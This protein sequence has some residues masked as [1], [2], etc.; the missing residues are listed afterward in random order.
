MIRLFNINDYV[1]DTGALTGLHD[2]I[3]DEFEQQIADFVGAKYACGVSSATNA[4]FLA[5]QNKDITVEVPSIIPPVV[6]NAILTSGNHV[7]FRDDVDWVG[8]SYVLHNFGDYKLV[9][10]AQKIV[11]NQFKL[12]C[13]PQDLMIFSFYPTKPIGSF[14]GAL[15][16]SDDKKKI[17]WFKI[18][19]KN[20]ME[21]YH[22]SWKRKAV[23]PGFKMYLNAIQAYIGNENYKKLESKYER[24]TEVRNKYNSAFNLKNDSCHLYRLNVEN[25]KEFLEKAKEAGIEIGIHYS[26]I[27]LDPIY[28]KDILSLPKSEVESETTISLPFNECLSEENIHKVVE[29]VRSHGYFKNT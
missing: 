26:A 17:E 23:V 4:I 9:D 22:Q 11:E 10:S 24:L 29:L 20:G 28:C 13:D 14:D 15:I 2:H 12:E 8:D 5:L 7:A 6:C 3:V 18:L 21:F 1:I 16:V 27:H 25:R 19:T